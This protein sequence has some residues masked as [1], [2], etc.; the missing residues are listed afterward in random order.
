MAL[1]EENYPDLTNE[2]VIRFKQTFLQFD[3]NGGVDENGFITLKDLP[4]VIRAAGFSPTEEELSEMTT[5]VENEA[6][7]L[8]RIGN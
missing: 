6:P 1:N 7:L 3:S 8:D 2:E 5:K 4:I